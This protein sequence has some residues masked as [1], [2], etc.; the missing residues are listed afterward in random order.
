[1]LPSA[2]AG[3][4]TQKIWIWIKREYLEILPAWLFFFSVATVYE[5]TRMLILAE[6]GIHFY[7]FA[8]AF[9]VA[10]I[11]AKIL[12]IMDHSSF[13]DRFHDRPLIYGT[14]W[15]TGIYYLCSLILQY[16]EPFTRH[17]IKY[18]SM[19]DANREYWREM[20]WP[21]FWDAQVWTIIALAVFCAS[22]EMAR[23]LGGEKLRRL[24]FGPGSR[25]S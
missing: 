10:A 13:I 17:L 16:L 24:F 9:V 22:R 11:I 7:G 5:L 19:T 25:A 8:R 15:K 20:I 1:M 23:A 18:G 6:Y 14:L 3:T 2:M 12:L 21:R 4:L